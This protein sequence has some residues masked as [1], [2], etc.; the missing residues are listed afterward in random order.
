MR[1]LALSS[2]LVLSLAVAPALVAQQAEAGF[3]SLFDGKSLS[4]WTLVGGRGEGYGVK[5]GV[6]FCAKGGGGKLLTDKEYSD[7]VLRF[8]FKMPPEGSNNGLGIRAPRE[9]DAAYQGMELQIIDEAAALSGKWGTLKDAQ[10][11]GSVYGVIAAKKGAMKPAGQWNVQEVT[12]KGK[13]I[14]V[15]LNGQTILDADLSTVTDP[16]VLKQH[17]GVLRTSGHIGLLGHN[18]YI[19]FRN[20]RIKE[21]R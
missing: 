12:A 9:G 14:T 10:Y 6:L 19:E 20:I 7:F 3:T 13:Q 5:D 17:P 16:A 2:V 4:G 18:D 21:L 11:H 8:E 1:R 15:V